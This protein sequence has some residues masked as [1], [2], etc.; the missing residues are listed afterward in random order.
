MIEWPEEFCEELAQRG[1]YV[2]RFDNRDVGLS[3]KIEEGGTPD[4]LAAV[5]VSQSGGK[6]DAPYSIDDMADD[7]V[8]L[9][10][11]IGI[12]RAHICGLS[13]GGMIAQTLAVRHPS[14][15]R[16]LI[17]I[18]STTGNPDLPG[19]RPEVMA[20]LMSP[21]PPEREPY[22]EWRCR[23]ERAIAGPALPP[24]ERRVREKS[25]RLFDRSF[26]PPGRTRQMMAILAHG[27]RKPALAAVTAPTLVIHGAEDPLVPVAAGP[28][29]AEAIAG[30]ELLIIERMGHGF[31]FPEVWPRIADAIAAHTRRAES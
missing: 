8:G 22:V 21:P 18:M 7:T 12:E 20:Q 5:A 16:S 28:D 4:L 1:H 26:Y 15:I 3:S 29:T 25:A 9:L 30:A 2:I 27:N 19:A 23:L 10:D 17:S 6:A 14:R 13:M 11:A 31:L 24:D